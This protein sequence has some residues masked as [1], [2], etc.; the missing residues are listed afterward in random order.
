MAQ[1]ILSIEKLV[2]RGLAGQE[3]PVRE[4]IIRQFKCVEQRLRDNVGGPVLIRMTFSVNRGCNMTAP[5]T[6]DKTFS[7]LAFCSEEAATGNLV[8]GE[9][10]MCHFPLLGNRYIS[11]VSIAMP[12]SIG[13]FHEV[14][15]DWRRKRALE[16]YSSSCTTGF[17]NF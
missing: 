9:R 14:T 16:P 1:E 13:A 17:S 10:G 2:N 12:V 3:E 11:P 5:I 15:D 8:F 4:K 6:G 7:T